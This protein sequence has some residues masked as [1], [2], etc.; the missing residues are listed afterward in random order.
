MRKIVPLQLQQKIPNVWLERK[1]LLISKNYMKTYKTDESYTVVWT[2]TK[3][4]AIGQKLGY[5]KSSSPYLQTSSWSINLTQIQSWTQSHIRC[6]FLQELVFPRVPLAMLQPRH[7]IK[8][9]ELPTAQDRVCRAESALTGARLPS[10]AGHGGHKHWAD[11]CTRK[12]ISIRDEMPAQKREGDSLWVNSSK[13]D[14]ILNILVK[15]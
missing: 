2:R 14:R 5:S 3:S 12:G 11:G 1:T 9:T 4:H 6:L 10:Q 15:A 7:P 8:G 13:Q